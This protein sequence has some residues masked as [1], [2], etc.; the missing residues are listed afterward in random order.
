MGEVLDS[1]VQCRV[2]KVEHLPIVADA[3]A[4]E[5]T[6]CSHIIL[7][8]QPNFEREMIPNMCYQLDGGCGRSTQDLFQRKEQLSTF[9]SKH[10]ITISKSRTKYIIMINQ[11]D[12]APSKGDIVDVLLSN[13]TKKKGTKAIFLAQCEHLRIH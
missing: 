1:I 3:L 2:L 11:L 12:N 6:V 9:R 5:C 4:Y 13:I 8:E 10:K 7:F